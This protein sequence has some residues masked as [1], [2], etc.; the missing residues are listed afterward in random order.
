[1]FLRGIVGVALLVCI[2]WTMAQEPAASQPSFP[3]ALTVREGPYIIHIGS[4]MGDEALEYATRF[5]E[6]TRS[7]HKYQ[8]YIFSLS[9]AKANKDREDL[10]QQQLKMLGSDKLYNSNEPQKLRTVRIAKEYSVFVGSFP[11]MEKARYEAVRI[12]ELPPPT[13]IPSSGVH[14]YKE[15]STKA[16]AD[17]EAGKYG[18]FGMRANVQS[19]EGKRL[20]D[21]VGN[22]Y[23]QAFVVMNPLRTQDKPTTVVTQQSEVPFDPAWK[24]LNAKEQY[25]IFT[26][27]KNWTIVV[28]QFTPPADVQSTMRP[29]VV[30]TGYTTSNRDLGKGLERAAETARQI[31]ELLRDGGKGYDTYVFHTREYSIVTVGAFD[32]RF[33]P[34]MAQAWETLKNFAVSQEKNTNS[35]F[36]L[37]MTVPRPMQ[38]PGRQMPANR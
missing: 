16:K 22:P 35:P 17:P 5:A 32:S 24:E 19:E 7:K 18:M 2:T 20:K 38:V 27:P 11:D 25:S 31:A 36:S 15:S 29:S 33:D 37:L 26:C 9:D 4:F 10:R 3:Y 13:S 6:E 21:S 12:K 8:T 28:A 1:M 14:L 23:R 34:N 30:Q